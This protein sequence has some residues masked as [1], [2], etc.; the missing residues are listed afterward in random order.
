MNNLRQAAQ[1]ALQA[2]EAHGAH[3]PN[4]DHLILLTSLPPQR[5]PC[6]CG[7]VSA[8]T[9]L[10]AALAEPEQ[11]AAHGCHIDLEPGQSADACVFDDGR[12]E[13]CAYAWKLQREG[14]GKEACAE[15]R[16]IKLIKPTPHTPV[17]LTDEEIALISGECAASAHRH[18]D[19]RF[20]RSVIVAYQKKQGET[21]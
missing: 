4:C 13:D 19:F 12:I 8:I 18:D 5:K 11:I 15:W 21:K 7:L 2:L 10:R 6:S 3:A 16:P 14:K 20:A 1:Q 17:E 9:N